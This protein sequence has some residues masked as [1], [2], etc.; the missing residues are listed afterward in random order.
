MDTPFVLVNS[1]RTSFSGLSCMSWTV[2]VMEPFSRCGESNGECGMEG[3]VSALC[4]KEKLLLRIT[5]ST[6][7]AVRE[8][9]MANLLILNWGR[10][11]RP[12]ARDLNLNASHRTQSLTC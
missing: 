7:R 10:A 8:V 12:G 2:P 4:A 5:A 1:T 9:F 11:N 3:P 6:A